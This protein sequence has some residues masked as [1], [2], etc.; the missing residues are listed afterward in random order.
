MIRW[1]ISARIWRAESCTR[2]T[3][4]T[5]HDYGSWKVLSPANVKF[6]GFG[7]LPFDPPRILETIC[8]SKALRVV[9]AF[10][11]YAGSDRSSINTVKWCSDGL[12]KLFLVKPG[13]FC[14]SK[15]VFNCSQFCLKIGSCTGTEIK[16]VNATLLPRSYLRPEFLTSS[17]C[18]FGKAGVEFSI[19]L[20]IDR[21]FRIG[22]R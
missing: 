3:Y 6:K 20:P 15:L 16:C 14:C 4:T 8:D 13:I 2:S 1:A 17:S 10:S 11:S 7:S 19:T 5:R 18:L 22:T 21:L 9:L 12:V